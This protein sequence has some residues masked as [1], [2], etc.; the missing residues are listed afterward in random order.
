MELETDGAGRKTL[1]DGGEINPCELLHS[2]YNCSM[3]IVYG[4]LSQVCEKL[5]TGKTKVPE[6]GA[7]EDEL[8]IHVRPLLR[9]KYFQ[10]SRVLQ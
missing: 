10:Y 3:L 2:G 1:R 7:T 5:Q 4:Y 6:E 8:S 9:D